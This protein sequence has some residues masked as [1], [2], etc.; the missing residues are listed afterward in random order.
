MNTIRALPALLRVGF[1]ETLAYRVEFI[2]WMLTT[3]L[4]LI[5][6]GLWTSVAHEG[7]FGRF[8]SADFVAY[9]LGAL[10]VRNLTG[11]WAVWQINE[12]IRLGTLS[13]RLL[14][15]IHPLVAYLTT[16][17]AAVPL[18]GLVALPLTLILLW[19]QAGQ[20]LITDAPRLSIFAA[21]L[22]GAFALTFM[23]MVLIATLGF[24][25][26]RS[27]AIFDIYLGLFAVLSG[28]LV[29]L[30]LL[31]SWVGTIAAFTPF[32]YMLAFPV[33]TLIGF[34]DAETALSHLLR[35]WIFVVV[36]TPMTLTFWRR[37]VR[38]FEAYGS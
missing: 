17:L 20:I 14:K 16:H 36:L 32:Q 27:L 22:V 29:P 1:A 21:S 5:M 30:E 34:L 15:P 31:P 12:D 18:R 11:N 33:E 3:T 6:L 24:Y 9:Y 2:I 19:S 25:F 8:G 4:P 28:Y 35:Q 26:E 13:Q 23:L 38:R 10:V 37:G 7:P